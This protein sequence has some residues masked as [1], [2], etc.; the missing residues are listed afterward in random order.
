MLDLSWN[1]IS[2]IDENYF[3]TCHR[4]EGIYMTGNQLSVIPNL[5]GASRTLRNLRLDTNFISDVTPL[6]NTHLPNLRELKLYSNHITS[7]CFPPLTPYLDVVTLLSNRL[8][9]IYF[10]ELNVT[11]Q[12]KVYISLEDNLWHCNGSL[13]WTKYCTPQPPAYMECMGWFLLMKEIICTSPKAVQGLTATESGE[14]LLP[15]CI[16]PEKNKH[17]SEDWS[18]T[19]PMALRTDCVKKSL[20]GV[21]EGFLKYL[22]LQNS[23]SRIESMTI[24]VFCWLDQLFDMAYCKALVENSIGFK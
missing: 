3:D 8:S 11:R 24:R 9:T 1:N 17:I 7:F 16:K 6:Y 23:S 20:L 14:S 4:V 5:K 21:W 2:K 15:H 22:H 18:F 19:I 13:G 12:R 10:S